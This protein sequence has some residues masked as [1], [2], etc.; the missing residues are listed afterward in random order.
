MMSTQ[1]TRLK[2][3]TTLALRLCLTTALSTMAY[4]ACADEPVLLPKSIPHEAAQPAALWKLIAF[5]N[6][7]V[8]YNDNIY[9][10]TNHKTS[11]LI[12]TVAPSIKLASDLDRHAFSL[13]GNVE[14]GRYIKEQD[15]DYLDASVD[16]A[17]RFD[18]GAITVLQLDGGYEKA[19][20]DIG[21]FEDEPT[22]RSLKPTD[23]N[24]G[25]AAVKLTVRPSD[26]LYEIGIKA[27]DYDY[28]NAARANGTISIN[29]DRD[30][31]EYRPWIKA[32]FYTAPE[33]LFYVKADATRVTYDTMIDSSAL[34]ERDS[35]GKGASLGFKIGSTKSLRWL[36]VSV[37][38][39]SRD[40]KDSYYDTIST[41]GADAQGAW[42]LT[43]HW[44]LSMNANRD[45]KESSLV[46]SSAYV[47]SRLGGELSYAL[48][49]ALS[50][51]GKLR[52]TNNDFSAAPTSGVDDRKDHVYDAGMGASYE[53][54]PVYQ[55]D[56]GVSHTKRTSNNA[57][58]EYDANKALLSLSA[59]M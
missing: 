27:D 49:Q 9:K 53:L 45:I 52:Y 33:R 18:M 26:L 15:N 57:S 7:G 5:G 34:H 10:D 19:H 48:S 17:A 55:L 47:Q 14:G 39:I 28:D 25:N 24:H 4:N 21:S 1:H 40:F 46:A 59:K 23:Y 37:G 2:N 32:G 35:D 8:S 30:R 29:D 36:D 20:I 42:Q 12:A 41:I 54:S 13:T 50:L 16:G 43:P 38:Y 6:T 31:R 56:F 51:N 44:K 22:D 3:R 58:V 11:D